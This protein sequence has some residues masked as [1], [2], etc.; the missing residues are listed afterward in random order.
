MKPRNQATPCPHTLQH[1][2]ANQLKRRQLLK[3]ATASL[4]CSSMAQINY[5][6]AQP[7]P[8]T[9]RVAWRNWSGI[10]SCQAKALETPADEA[11]VIR[12]LRS[13]STTTSTTP[14]TPAD[15]IR[16]VGA[17]HSFTALVPT[18]GKLIS[19]DQLSGLIAHDKTALTATLHAG[20]RLAQLSRQL[21]SIGLALPN[22]PDVNAQSFAGAISTATHGT[23]RTHPAL[24]A[25]VTALR[26]ITPAGEVL[27]CS[28]T[29]RPE[30]LAAA[31][32]ALGSLGII[33]AVTTKVVPAFNLQRKVWLMPLEDM[34]AQADALSRSNQ[35]FE[36]FY[37]PF[38]GYTAAITHNPYAGKEIVHPPGND[39]AMLADLRKLR[40]WLGRTPDLRRWVAKKMID[41]KLTEQATDRSFK[42]F[43]SARPTKFNETECHVPREAGIACVREIIRKLEQRNEVFFPLE[44]RFVAADQAWLSPFYQRDS[45]SIAV[46]A[47]AGEPYDYIVS[48]LGPIFRKYGARPHWGK[49]HDYSTAELATLYPRWKDFLALRQQLDPRGRMLNPYVAKLLGVAT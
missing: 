11:A 8:P 3:L 29:E 45:C 38:T 6:Q 28:Q 7:A 47:A 41:P 27:T 18:E 34:L 39:E 49:L 32:V 15:R 44:F 5:A 2:P 43:S 21:D 35:H 48:E 10:Q 26:L 1:N 17:G 46:H 24:H 20:T 14:L 12:L 25:H 13:L 40:D 30:L 4:A 16:C 42:L 31:Q 33:T 22:L 9:A 37:L 19:L 36:F 23:G